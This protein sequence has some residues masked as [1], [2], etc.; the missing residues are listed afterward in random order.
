MSIKVI[1]SDA[2]VHWLSN[3][4]SKGTLTPDQGILYV[5]RDN[6]LGKATA[7]SYAGLTPAEAFKRRYGGMKSAMSNDFIADD[8]FVFDKSASNDA[9]AD[10]GA[11]A[12]RPPRQRSADRATP[13]NVSR[14]RW[15][16]RAGARSE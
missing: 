11:P 4:H 2:K 6:K 13:V 1:G 3:K 9:D 10:D 15:R 12:G 7:E 8:L 5:T 16:C 14:C